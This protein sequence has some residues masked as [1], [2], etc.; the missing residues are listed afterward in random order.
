MEQTAIRKWFN[1]NR[2][3]EEGLALLK[4]VDA[5]AYISIS[6][7]APQPTLLCS[8]LLKH[9]KK[10]PVQ[11]TI[12][13]PI[14]SVKPIVHTTIANNSI[15]EQQKKKADKL[16]KEMSNARALLFNLCPGKPHRF[17]NEGKAVAERA[18]LTQKVMELQY[19]VDKA[20]EDYQFALE[21]NRLPEPIPTPEVDKNDVYRLILNA[22]K[23][24]SK[25]LHQ[26][27]E[28]SP[29]QQERLT[30]KQAE[31]QQLLKIYNDDKL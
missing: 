2:Q 4:Q 10:T 24:I 9:I 23:Y 3:Y 6:K 17:E 20:Y 25:Y 31:L 12:P 13:V 15:A 14:P 27:G 30:A 11:T 8:L 1:S 29:A 21:H 28:L 18:T 19:Q 22:R 7:G 26:K 16:Y 5:N